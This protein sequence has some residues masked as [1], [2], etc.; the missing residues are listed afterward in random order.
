VK[1]D[2]NNAAVL[3]VD[4][5]A[6]LLSLVRDGVAELP[7]PDGW[8]AAV[9][10]LRGTVLVNGH[11]LARDG[12]LVVLDRAGISVSIEAN[13]DAVVLLLAGEPIDE[14][15]VGYGPFVMNSEA[16]IAQAIEDFNSGRFG[17]IPRA[18]TTE[19]AS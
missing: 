13:N 11:A 6:G 10:V 3:L 1:L 8:T 2:K 7:L 19:T 12:Q 9:V 5:Q 14:S 16:E 15:I 17:V 4:H 18:K